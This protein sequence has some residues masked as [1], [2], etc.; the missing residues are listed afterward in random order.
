MICFD[1]KWDVQLFFFL[2]FVRC[3]CSFVGLSVCWW[4]CMRQVHTTNLWHV[5]HNIFLWGFSFW[6]PSNN[7]HT[8]L[9][10]SVLIG[11]NLYRNRNVS[12][13]LFDC[14]ENFIV[15]FCPFILSFSHCVSQLW[16]WDMRFFRRSCFRRNFI[17]MP[18]RIDN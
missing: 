14:I 10:F 7:Q 17:V 13:L 2:S 15:I 9:L 11:L 18:C 12:A 16:L 4:C 8:L 6:P 5:T 1:F 3:Y